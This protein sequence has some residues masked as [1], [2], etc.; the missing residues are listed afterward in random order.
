VASRL[1]VL[2]LK[3]RGVVAGVFVLGAGHAPTAV[4]AYRVNQL[5]GEVER[6]NYTASS[7]R[8][9]FALPIRSLMVG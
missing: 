1:K 3:I 9:Y 4:T 2:V 8:S 5:L 6:I 7:G